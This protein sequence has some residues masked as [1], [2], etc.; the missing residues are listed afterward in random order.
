MFSDELRDDAWVWFQENFDGVKARIP[1]FAQSQITNFAGDYCSLVKRDEIKAFFEPR[2]K[3]I[4][5]GARSLAQTLETIELCV[6]KVEF[7]GPKLTAFLA[8]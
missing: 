8:E 5:G 3:S 7:H 1:E 2:V 6:A 4:S